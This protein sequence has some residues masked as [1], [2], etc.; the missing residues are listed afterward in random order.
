MSADYTVIWSEQVPKKTVVQTFSEKKG[1]LAAR[2]NSNVKLKGRKMKL[3]PQRVEVKREA[4]LR[5]NCSKEC[6]EKGAR[7]LLWAG[8]VGGEHCRE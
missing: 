3:R 7:R 4:A 5:L 2:Q 6:K 8:G 1:S